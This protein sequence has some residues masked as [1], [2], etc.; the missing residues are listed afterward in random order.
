MQFKYPE[1]LYALFLLLIPIFVHLFQLRRFQ[2]VDFTNVAFLKKATIQTRKSSQLKKW[3]TLLARLLALAAI[4]FAFAQPFSASKK[5]LNTEKET[6]IYIDNSFSMEA[7]GP[8]GPMLKRAL[9]ELYEI[10]DGEEKISWFTNDEAKRNIS[11]SDFKSEVLSIGYSQNQWDLPDVLLKAKQLFSNSPT[12]LKRLV[13]ISDFQRKG[14]FPAVDSSFVVETIQTKPVIQSN[15]SIDTA[16]LVSKN[17]EKLQLA[18]IV[19]GM[20]E[21]PENSTISLLKDG[22]LMAKTGVDFSERQKNTLTFDIEYTTGFQGE[23]SINDPSLGYDNSLFFSINAE[24]KIKVLAIN[25]S[26]ADFLRKL[27]DSESYEYLEEEFNQLNYSDIPR[28]NLI[29]L[30]ELKTLPVSLVNSLKTFHDNGGTLSIIPAKE[31]DISSYN[32]LLNALGIATFQPDVHNQEKKMTKINFS[33]PLFQGVFEK[34]VSNFQYPTVQSYLEMNTLA[35]NVLAFEDNKPFLVQS[36]KT[37]LATAAFDS[38]NSNFKTSPL[39]VPTFINMAQQSLPTPKLYIENGEKNTYAVPIQLIQDEILTLK[40]SISSFI[41]LQQT[42]ANSVEITTIED[43]NKA[44]NYS[45]Y[46]GDQLLQRISYNYPRTESQLVYASVDDWK[47]V[48]NFTSVQELFQSI[49][50][51]NNRTTFW[52]WFVIF[53]VL[54]LIAEMSI[55]KFFK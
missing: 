54:F 8:N 7:K 28:Q 11:Q 52:K 30:N 10:L 42:K 14:A 4:I 1:I 38:G 46:K 23:I 6:V 48:Q 24:E 9:Q 47:G 44:G 17:T 2:K 13:I 53:A 36:G 16:Y 49:A 18:V 40:D 26:N 15:I 33:H 43:P 19:S 29:V 45:I 39:I 35:S 32:L 27:F 41:P 37:Y 34:E 31:L 12:A 25:Q 5:A 55:L 22:R 20:G 50:E 3:L 21:V 51:E